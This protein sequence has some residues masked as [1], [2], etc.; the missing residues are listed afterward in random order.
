VAGNITS[1]IADFGNWM[2]PLIVQSLVVSFRMLMGNEFL[3][4]ITQRSL[5][6]KEYALEAFLLEGWFEVFEIRIQIGEAQW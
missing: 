4:G 2:D 1:N 6:E 3:G 5:P